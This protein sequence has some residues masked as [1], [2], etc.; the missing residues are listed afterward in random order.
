MTETFE[1]Q[2]GRWRGFHKK[3]IDYRWC[4]ITSINF[5]CKIMI[6]KEGKRENDQAITEL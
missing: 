5:P 4:K 1:K 6:I 3:R 2:S